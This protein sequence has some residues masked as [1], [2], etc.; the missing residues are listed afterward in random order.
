MLTFIPFLEELCY[1]CL[2]SKS[3]TKDYN[4]VKNY[5]HN[6]LFKEI[7]LYKKGSDETEKNQSR[8]NLFGGALTYY[9]NDDF[10]FLLLNFKEVF[11]WTDSAILLSK[12]I[13]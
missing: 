7:D 9:N 8:R 6:D 1:F 12:S 11:D 4:K 10:L 5:L 2:C 3:I 13:L